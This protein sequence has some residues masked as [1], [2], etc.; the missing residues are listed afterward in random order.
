V[1][2]FTVMND[3]S[4]AL[5][6]TGPSNEVLAPFYADQ[7]NSTCLTSP[8][9]SM[10]MCSVAVY[11]VGEASGSGTTV[12]TLTLTGSGGAGSVSASLRG[13]TSSVLRI[14]PTEHDFGMVAPGMASEVEHF[15]VMND[16]AVALTLAVPSN[17]VLAPFHVDQAN[18]T[19]L[20]SPLPSM[21]MCSVA[22][23]YVGQTGGSGTSLRTLTLLANGGAGSVSASL[24]GTTSTDNLLRII[25]TTYDFGTVEPG[26]ASEVEH[27]TVMNDAAVALTLTA[28]S[29]EALAPFRVDHAHST[30]LTSPLPSMGMCSVA[31]YYVG[32]PIGSGTT[33]KT[34]TLTANGGVASVSATLT[35]TAA[36]V[37]RITPA[38]HDF[39]TVPPG[40]MT[41]L[42]RFT[43]VNDGP[44]A[45][46]LTAP[47]N[48]VLAPFHVHPASSSCLYAPVPSMGVCIVAVYYVA[49]TG[50]SGTTER[51][52][53][54]T[55]NGSA[56]SVSA[57]LR[58][59][60]SA[61]LMRIIPAEHDFGT[62]VPGMTTDYSYLTV[63]N[64]GA[65]ALTLT[66][67]ANEVL[68]PFHVH[69][70]S[71]SCLYA[72]LPSMGTCRVAAYYV[73]ET[74]GGG[75]TERT[76]TLTANGGA[77]SVSATLRGTTSMDN[78]LR[79][80][81]TEHDFGTVPPGVMTGFSYF[82][83]FNDGPVT[84]TLTA[85]SNEVLAPF[86]VHFASSSCLYA[87]V[88]SMGMCSVAVYFVG[89]ASES[90]TTERTLTLTATAG[91]SSASVMLRG[92]TSNVL[93]IIPTEHD[94]GTV[95]AGVM[96]EFAYFTVMND[97]AVALTLTGP[98]SQ[99]LAP[100]HLEW[101]MSSCLYA[102]VPSMGMCGVTAYYVGPASGSGTTTKALTLTAN[103]GAAEATATLTGTTP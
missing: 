91:A 26:M 24:R 92:T 85:P 28:P 12:R 9:P 74:S 80:T 79:I 45:L 100:F 72:P 52:L 89:E 78:M 88:P 29:N 55:A 2:Y 102:P 1:A 101:S 63:F 37:L 82:T 5:T 48:E 11:F 32:Q 14:I 96:S 99:D 76:L 43:V 38:E 22:V 23:Y 27:F 58:G 8:L 69:F 31:V 20:T 46:T 42:F 60:S 25:P 67:P 68:A 51:T 17:V 77:A 81:P 93:R 50:G 84:L 41:D 86:H 34:L 73:G 54:L 49:E 15:T 98:S 71:S 47:A 65:V 87:P 75:T 66:A 97:G 13:T 62:V 21:G 90:G 70:A 4:V 53:A 3:S 56:A 44:N 35:G 16:G 59:T 36:N 95:A 103:G 6:L 30:C 40:T 39:G 33:E 7:A 10:G 94:F 64:D 57:T 19:C 83:V 18:S 61:N